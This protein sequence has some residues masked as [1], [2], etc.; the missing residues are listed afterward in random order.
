MSYPRKLH[1]LIIEDD[2]SVIDG[3]RETFRLL[4]KTYSLVSPV[5]ARSFADAKSRIDSSSI[6]HL[7]ILD[8]N[9][10]MATREEPVDGFAPGLDL[11]EALAKRDEVP[12]P[13]VL[14]VSG[15]LNQ[16]HSTRGIKDRLANDFFYGALL[17][18]GS[19]DEYEDLSTGLQRAL[20]YVDVGIHIRDSGRETFPT[21]SPREDDLLRRCVLANSQ[22]LGVD[23]R[24]WSA[25]LGPTISRPSFSRGPT[26]VLMGHFLLDDG[27]EVSIPTFFKFEAAGNA[28]TVARD[29]GILSQ[30]LSHIKIIG[31]QRSRQRTV[32]VTQ[33]VTNRGVPVPLAEYLSRPPEVVGTQLPRLVSQVVEQLTHLGGESQ[34][35]VTVGTFFWAHLDRT[36][37]ER[38]WRAHLERCGTEEHQVSPL[39]LFDNLRASPTKYWAARRSCVHGDL[40]ATNVAIDATNENQP[41]AYIFDAAGMREDFSLRDLA[42]LEV[43]TVLFNIGIDGGL[44]DACHAFYNGTF[45]PVIPKHGTPLI[46]NILTLIAAVRARFDTQQTQTAYAILVF[47][48]VLGQLSGLGLQSSHNKVASPSDACRLAA[49]IAEWLPRVA[50]DLEIPPVLAP[51]SQRLATVT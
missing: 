34:D 8:L 36:A 26:K 35:N 28:P 16:P 48:A 33:S 41:E 27:M 20:S 22:T 23:L 18:K 3:Y 15:K 6:Y 39:E 45:S 12:V 24:W 42:V 1:V 47:D 43:T 50:A 32:L 21:L 40:N 30:K 25:E 11:L 13:V 7:V 17:T 10:P 37:I 31:T 38:T 2:S 29:V 46:Q 51:A 5:F 9:L 4:Q 49:W 14:V 44:L 19:V